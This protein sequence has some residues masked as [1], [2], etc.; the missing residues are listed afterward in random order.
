MVFSLRSDLCNYCDKAEVKMRSAH[1]SWR[2]PWRKSEPCWFLGQSTWD[3]RKFS[4]FCMNPKWPPQNLPSSN[5]IA[6]IQQSLWGISRQRLPRL[7]AKISVQHQEH[8]VGPF[9]QHEFSSGFQTPLWGLNARRLAVWKNFCPKK[10][11]T[12]TLKRRDLH[13]RCWVFFFFFFL[14]ETKSVL[15]GLSLK[16]PNGYCR[17]WRTQMPWWSISGFLWT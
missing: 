6:N 14:G 4:P 2:F 9:E 10:R 1:W 16:K 13:G 17:T 7:S 15:D 12:R 8:W 11:W 5:K 3:G